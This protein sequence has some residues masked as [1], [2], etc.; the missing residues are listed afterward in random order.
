MA[1]TPVISIPVDDSEFSKF[2]EAFEAYNEKLKEMPAAWQ[3]TNAR[4]KELA[5]LQ[6]SQGV[7]VEQAWKN[8]I[9]AST[10]YEKTVKKAVTAQSSL[11]SG[12]TR[13]SKGV[14]KLATGAKS[15]ASD[16]TRA[17]RS[18]LGIVGIGSAV[19]TLGIFGLDR[20]A[21]NVLSTSRTA[22]GLG[23]SVG[24][25]NSFRTNMARFAGVGVLQGAAGA[26]IDP[27]KWGYLAALGI[28]G[29]QAQS[30][31]AT[32]LAGQEILKIHQAWQANPTL[33][34]AA[35]QSA[36]QLGFTPEDIRRIGTA[37]GSE[38]Q[39]AINATSR[40]ASGLGF[41]EK[42][43]QEWSDFS[44]QLHKAGI[45]IE[46]TLIQTLTP[47]TPQ[48]TTLSQ[49][50]ADFIVGLEKSGLVKQ[51]I[52]SLADGIKS[53][54]SWIGSEDFKNDLKIIAYDFHAVA[55]AVA[56]VAQKLGF[57]PPPGTSPPASGGSG[58][59]GVMP[60]GS[61]ANGQNNY[62]NAT[63]DGT[64]GHWVN[65]PTVGF[66][67]DE[68]I[69]KY[70]TSQLYKNFPLSQQLSMWES[71]KYGSPEG[72]AYA[73]RVAATAGELLGLGHPLTLDKDFDKFT[74]HEQA[75]ILSAQSLWEKGKS[76]QIPMSQIESEAT[77]Q[78]AKY[79]D[80]VPPGTF[81]GGVPKGIMPK[82]PD[83]SHL[84]NR[85]VGAGISDWWHGRSSDTAHTR[86]SY[87]DRNKG[88]DVKIQNNTA[89]Q[90]FIQ[91][92]GAAAY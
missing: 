59:P 82:G 88:A 42:V 62:L 19:G 84:T 51:W 34:S 58:A 31:D 70:E 22:S 55:G 54:A 61:D 12:I 73:N 90:V 49:K 45:L 86:Q 23:L 8:A 26:Q 89:S 85:P 81:P 39:S 91:S 80:T 52:D 79:H 7:A 44:I 1:L 83:L 15:L 38:L 46:S 32:A 5:T 13:V 40:D 77:G 60:G 9:A 67:T 35:A 75:A 48:L 27:R 57:G 71:G 65:Y 20:L 43:A 74:P 14:G 41:S 53:F 25:Y 18:I 3:A 4:I 68:Y 66:A 30:E 6:V 28:S 69:R 11:E 64:P 10:A 87:W 37:K 63:T 29:Q 78:W 36:L 2:V 47:L 24:A 33:L 72:L 21:D 50:V 92:N 56:A 16:L 76:G 17:A